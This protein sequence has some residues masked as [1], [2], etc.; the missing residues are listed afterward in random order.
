MLV[1]TTIDLE[2]DS[3]ISVSSNSTSKRMWEGI[4][5]PPTIESL[6]AGPDSGLPSYVN[7][8]TGFHRTPG[9]VRIIKK[10][11]NG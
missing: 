2:P 10:T 7:P 5:K 8:K 3:S 11:R 6:I 1:P 9:E 4:V